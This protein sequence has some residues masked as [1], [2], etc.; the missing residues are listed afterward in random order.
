MFIHKQVD[1]VK[2]SPHLKLGVWE[3]VKCVYGRFTSLEMCQFEGLFSLWG[4]QMLAW[5]ASPD[6]VPQGMGYL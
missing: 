3:T 4:P 2:K 1:A 5:F 6:S